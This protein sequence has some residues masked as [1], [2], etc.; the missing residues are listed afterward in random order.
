[1]GRR[2]TVSDLTDGHGA[3]AK[4]T[5]PVRA[6]ATAMVLMLG[7]CE[8]LG[9]GNDEPAPEAVLLGVPMEAPPA[10]ADASSEET[11]PPPEGADL[12]VPAEAS[13]DD[14][15]A[16]P[17][18]LPPARDLMGQPLVTAP[19]GM[20]VVQ[21]AEPLTAEFATDLPALA[22]RAADLAAN[23]TADERLS[24]RNVTGLPLF[25]AA[26]PGL[27]FR[28]NGL[29]R[30]MT[31]AEPA[32]CSYTRADSGYVTPEEAVTDSM[33]RCLS[34]VGDLAVA[35]QLPC[36]CKLAALDEVLFVPPDEIDWRPAMPALTLFQSTSQPEN[37]SG[38]YGLL[39]MNTGFAFGEPVR[40]Y[41]KD[42]TIACEGQ[43]SAATD[44]EGSLDLTCFD[45]DESVQ[46]QYRIFGRY[47]G[48]PYG[49][50]QAVS[51][52][53]RFLVLFGL[54][55]QSFDRRLR[56]F[57]TGGSVGPGAVPPAPVTEEPL[58]PAV[59]EPSAGGAAPPTNSNGSGGASGPTGDAG[60]AVPVPAPAPLGQDGPLPI[61]APPPV[62]PR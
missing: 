16:P 30:A 7:A 15:T 56:Q 19:L 40:I 27:D 34:Y 36:E 60:G 26:P 4:S 1:M 61:P 21:P 53:R 59:E 31:V 41:A 54:D 42:G 18:R 43:R 62:A 33:L 50:A 2:M 28:R 22:S 46:G 25:S 35:L 23:A 45:T 20:T 38:F 55:G 47:L 48:E 44:R 8:S 58:A 51:D 9:I 39:E 49:L 5:W 29:H 10:D 14:A 13:Q 12:A 32:L 3:P 24:R 37:T 52:Q 11:G 17:V 57:R 6:L